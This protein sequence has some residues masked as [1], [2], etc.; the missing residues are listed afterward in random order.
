MRTGIGYDIHRLVPGRMLILGGVKIDYHLG[1]LAH[2]DGDV[3]IH[4]IIDS[5]LGA[6][7]LGDIGEF[8]PDTDPAYKDSDSGK[9]LIQVIN[10][11]SE[12]GFTIEHVDVI[13]HAERPKL[14]GHKLMIREK[15]AQLMKIGLD[16]INLKAK[17]NEGLDAV[18][19]G[20]AIAAWVVATVAKN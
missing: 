13:I 3:V 8:F 2:S 7:C 4:A 14:S 1:F 17:T 19:E 15:L 10:L 6:C 11:I 18:G 12:K 9:L 16:R 5:L 20:H